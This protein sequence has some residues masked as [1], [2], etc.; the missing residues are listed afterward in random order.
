MNRSDPPPSLPAKEILQIFDATPAPYLV[1]SPDFTIVAANDAYLHATLTRREEIVGRHMFDVFPDNPQDPEAQGVAALTASLQR[2]LATRA[3]DTMPVQKYDIQKPAERG[4]GFEER[5]WSPVNSPVFDDEGEVAYIIHRVEDVTDF[6]R[7]KQQLA[8]GVQDAVALSK[9]IQELETEMFQRSRER[10]ETNKRL[11]EA[12]EALATLD[13]AKTTFFGNVNHE[14]RTPLT[15]MLGPLQDLMHSSGKLNEQE[16]QDLSLAYRNAQR[17]HKLVNAVLE[18][19]RIEAGRLDAAYEPTDVASFTSEL[20]GVF[21]SAIERAGLLLIIKCPPLSEMVFIDR[22][23]WEKIVLNLLSNAFKFTLRGEIEVSLRPT[24]EGAQ[25]VVRDTGTGIPEHELPR[26]FERFHRIEGTHGRTAEG[27]GIGLALVHE[28]VR[29]HAGTV[30]VASRQGEGTIFT[31]TV[32]FGREHLPPDRVWDGVSPSAHPSNAGLYAEEALSWL[33]EEARGENVARSPQPRPRILLAEDNTDMRGYIT[34]LLGKEYDV[35][36]VADGN[37]ALAAVRAAPPDL[38]LTDVFMLGLNGVELVREI[39]KDPR[40]TALPIIILS[41]SATEE[42]RIEGIQAGADDYL[43][44]PFSGRELLA[45]IAGQLAQ[46]EYVRRE[47]ALRTHAEAVQAQLEMVLESVNDAF[48]AADWNWRI[49]YVNSKAASVVGRIREALIGE[50]VRTAYFVDPNGAVSEALQRAM[51][52]RTSEC[53]EARD[54]VG[55]RWWDIRVF[56]SSDGLVVFSADITERRNAEMKLR[57]QADELRKTAEALRASET[58]LALALRAGRSVVWEVD[59]KTMTIVRPDDELFTMVGYFPRELPTVANWLSIIHEEDRPGAHELIDDVL[60]GKRDSYWVELRFVDKNGS[61]RWILCQAV[62]ADRDARGRPR[63]LVGTHTD[64]NDRK[65]AEHQVREAALHDPLT[66]LP[67]RA[68][69]FEY[70]EHLLAGAR[71]RHSCGAVL[72]VDLDRFKQI[73][74][75]YGHKVGDGVLQEV[76]KRLVGCTRREDL[77]GR[78]GGDEF[79]IVLPHIDTERHRAAA[80]ARHVIDTVSKPFLID[81]LELSLSPSVGVSYCPEHGTDVS[82][83]IHAADLAMYQA[84]QAGRAN[85]QFFTPDLYHRADAAYSIEARLKSALKNNGFILH[86][87]PVMDITQN[88]LVGAEALVRLADHAGEQVGPD[89][90]IPIA[91][92]AGLIGQ[93]GEWV[94]AEACRQYEAWRKNGLLVPIAINVS[95]LQFRQRDFAERL[96]AIISAAGVDSCSL[97]V[98]VTE[99]T[100]MESVDEAVEILHKLKSIGVKTVIDDFGTGYSSLN[101]LSSLPFDKLKVDQSFVQRIESDHASRAVTD[102]ILALGRSLNLEVVGEGIESENALRYLRDHGCD[103]AQGFWF[104]KPLPATEFAQWCRERQVR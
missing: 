19:T 11:R 60:E 91:E 20:A 45:R 46:F 55:G 7:M 24:D 1:M 51:S 40:L 36:A 10:L 47:Q 92:A 5:Y 16:R 42:A 17:L 65:L 9:R 97:Q 87:Q 18:F 104:S 69:I 88:R 67:N 81:N 74:D 62:G 50:D 57:E 12:N 85:F 8:E 56:P 15:L 23:M 84:K 102:A 58:R 78:L 98:E 49:T 37:A 28:L 30:R 13:R 76:A 44:K 35:E 59:V 86:Y 96:G 2:V 54:T 26:L 80:V 99:S 68:L 93:L 52:G 14:L 32:P 82:E 41:A 61:W 66:G 101:T 73:N 79:L 22:E 43:V 72:F 94:A 63:R 70:T 53:V 90:F 6:V 48:V 31:V 4:G 33:P 21:R 39:R 77:V 27:A 29:L 71:R 95:A 83:L 38:V 89:T 25:L 75:L 100:V 103:Q 64:I 3:P 34:R